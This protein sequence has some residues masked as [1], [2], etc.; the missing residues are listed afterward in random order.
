MQISMKSLFND[1]LLLVNGVLMPEAHNLNV[2]CSSYKNKFINLSE[3]EFLRNKD[4]LLRILKI[5]NVK[6]EFFE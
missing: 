6:F 4:L 1:Y 3:R 5:W 2:K